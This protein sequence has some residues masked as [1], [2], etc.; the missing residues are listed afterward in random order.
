MLECLRISCPLLLLSLFPR[1][2]GMRTTSPPPFW[3][4]DAKFKHLRLAAEATTSENSSGQAVVISCNATLK[5][6]RS[7]GEGQ[8]VVCK[9]LL[10]QLPSALMLRAEDMDVTKSLSNYALDSLVA[11]EVQREFEANL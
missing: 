7:L 10:N 6:A 3:T 1:T 5:A 9:G 11:I 4:A 8:D 2:A